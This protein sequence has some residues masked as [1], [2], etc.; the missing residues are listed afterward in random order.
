MS[1]GGARRNAG[2][3]RSGRRQICLWIRTDALDALEPGASKKIRDMVE[4]RFGKP[5]TILHKSPSV[6]S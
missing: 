4:K 1:R 6:E 5:I 2:R 3:P